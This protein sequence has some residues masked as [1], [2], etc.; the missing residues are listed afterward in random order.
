ME[1]AVDSESAGQVQIP[2]ETLIVE[3]DLSKELICGICL[4]ILTSPKQCKNGHLFCQSCILMHIEKTPECP[5]CRCELKEATLAR[6][7]F[8]ERHLRTLKLHCK[9][10]FSWDEERREFIADPD[11]GCNEVLTLEAASE[12][13]KDCGY[14]LVHCRYAPSK[15]ER[16]R[17]HSVD[18]HELVCPHRPLDCVHCKLAIETTKMDEHVA[19]CPMV[20][21]QCAKCRATV[22]R[23]DS[24]S[25]RQKACA[26]EIV[27]C[28]VGQGCAVK[29]LRKELH[30]HLSA[31]V[32]RHMLMMK[33]DFDEQLEAMRAKFDAQLK[34]RD[35]RI[36][37]LEKS[38]AE[39]DTKIDWRV[40]PWSS[41]RKKSYLQSGKFTFAD[42]N[43][44]I[45][46][47]TDGDNE[48][49]RGFISV[50]LFLDTA[51][52]PKGKTVSVE[53]ML[54]FIN[55]KNP[56]DSVKKEFKTTFPIK[57]GQGWGDRKAIKTSKITEEAGFL[58]KD[59]LYVEAQ[60]SLKK[61][62]W[63]LQ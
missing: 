50:Y 28:P 36:K 1:S 7:L 16:M 2:L 61:L 37:S 39:N 54:K 30:E 52:I 31:D 42:F 14:A 43:W 55:H 18:K 20:P 19:V 6:S 33:R 57:G 10:H 45:G 47:Y 34:V 15:C 49:S 4:Q 8:V 25:H 63:V 44:F 24:E 12:H 29:M 62:V 3:K 22:T 26:E 53:F 41:T 11:S 59:T 23:G 58:K 40:K 60:I 13:E 17:K 51:N 56:A 21:I 32:G 9:F 38:Q 46:F 5:S 35:D 48:D 27:P